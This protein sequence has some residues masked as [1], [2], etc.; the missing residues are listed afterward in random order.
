M[1]RALL[2]VAALSAAACVPPPPPGGS[3]GS[4]DRV[5]TYSLSQDSIERHARSITY[6]VR[7][8]SCDGVSLGSAFAISRNVLVTNRHVVDGGYF[9]LELSTWDG[10][11]FVVDASGV[12]RWADIA[13]IR[14]RQRLPVVAEIGED[15]RPGD[16]IGA[17]GFPRGGPW[18]LSTGRVV[19]YAPSDVFG[20]TH[21]VIRFDAPVAPGNSGG[22]LINSDGVVVGVVFAIE[23]FGNQFSLAIPVSTLLMHINSDTG[24]APNP[25]AC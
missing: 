14:T 18:T 17:V 23:R 16:R 4:L 2:M 21:E 6:R 19:D 3:S 13:V 7:N 22:P 12:S 9:S 25:P 20:T 15:P 8:P 1:K 11:D 5:E 24:I 10:R